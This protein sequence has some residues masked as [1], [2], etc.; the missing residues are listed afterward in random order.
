MTGPEAAYA[1]MTSGDPGTL[2]GAAADVRSAMSDLKDSIELIGLASDTPDWSSPTART[3]F[4]MNAW[5]TR[6]SAEVSFIR[7][8]R[9][10]LA[11]HRVS[12]DYTTMTAA[13]DQAIA[14][15]RTIKAQP[16]DPVTLILARFQ[17]LLVLRGI[18]DDLGS[19]IDEAIDF[20][21]A[22]PL[23]SDQQAWLTNGLA[24][25][26]R[27][28][29]ED[30]G[31]L[32]PIIP[33][34]LAGGDDDG[35]T[36]QGLGYDPTTGLL[37]QTSYDDD[38]SRIS[39]VDPETGEQVSVA[40]LGQAVDDQG[41]PL[42]APDHGGGV[43]V[44][45]GKVYVMSSSHPPSMYTYSMDDVRNASPG[46]SVPPLTSP[47]EMPAAAY[48]TI[49]GDTLYAG[50]FTDDG[51]TPGKLYTFTYDDRS[52][53]W[54]PASGPHPTPPQTQGITVRGDD[55]V[56][57]TSWGRDQQG[58]LESYHLGDVTGAA[59]GSLPHPISTVALPTMAEGVVAM[60]DGIFTTYESGSSSYSRPTGRQSLEDLWAGLQMTTTPYSELGLGGGGT[61]DVEPT[62]L[63]Q[64]SSS[65]D[66]AEAG[67]RSGQRAIG[68]ISLPSGCLGD[69]PQ[70]SSFATAVTTHCDETSD[71]LGQG[72]IAAGVTASGL[73]TA[74][75][76]Y[77]DSDSLIGGII[78][79]LNPFG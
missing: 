59:D 14:W 26:M 69:V 21:V 32:G 23:T 22:D 65:F 77:D 12:A 78:D 28:D 9:A 44:R 75:S 67:L 72:R 19:G 30:P 61:I 51:D 2:S 54:V 46:Q 18:R 41:R 52:D 62:T 11:L 79:R 64:A 49:V 45:D 40:D 74:A 47:Q 48:S 10:A 6:A 27:H 4:N 20:L 37:V 53:S 5:A 63:R 13:A 34:T 15:W 3:R 43:A 7:L 38:A 76:A 56:F 36:P 29:L 57:S 70:G 71:W 31:G 1:A 55:V 50:T 60:P 25:S 35:F 33:G 17:T 24:R 16:V 42:G 73:V 66:Q 58:A 68:T 8:N 39:L